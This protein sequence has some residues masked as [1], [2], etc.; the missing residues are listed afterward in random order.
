MMPEQSHQSP[1]VSL[2][3]E[4]PAQA[5]RNAVQRIRVAKSRAVERADSAALFAMDTVVDEELV[6]VEQ[7]LRRLQPS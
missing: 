1:V 7:A 5:I 3:E 4:D 2:V 6:I